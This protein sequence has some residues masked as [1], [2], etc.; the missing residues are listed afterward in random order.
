[1]PRLTRSVVF[2]NACLLLLCGS[3]SLALRE[4]DVWAEKRNFELT[5][6]DVNVMLVNNQEFHTF[7]FNGQVPGPL[8]H[9]KEGDELTVK[10][11]N[12]TTLPHTIHWHGIL[13]RGTWQSDGVQDVTQ[14]AIQP[15]ESFTYQFVA[16]PSGSLWYHCHVNVNEHVAIR[17]MWGPLIIDP[18]QPTP[19]AWTN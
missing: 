18:K 15:G 13:Q 11:T 2:S 16:E 5:I 9:V 1:M 10:V 17:G 12:L 14:P 7:A 4:G 8:M 19:I 3:F 6:E